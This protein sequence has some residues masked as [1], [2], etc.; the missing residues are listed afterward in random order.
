MKVQTKAFRYRL[1]VTV[2]TDTELANTTDLVTVN[3]PPDASTSI[4]VVPAEGD[5]ITHAFPTWA[6]EA[7]DNPFS[8]VAEI[9]ESNEV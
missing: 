4:A 6:F 3:A 1:V 5:T 7:P 2:E 9:S 8:V